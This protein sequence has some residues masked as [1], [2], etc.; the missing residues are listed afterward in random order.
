MGARAVVSGRERPV[1]YAT[2]AE[3]D[4]TSMTTVEKAAFLV[5]VDLFRDVPSDALAELASRVEEVAHV[6]GEVLVDG[7]ATEAR[8]LVVLDG[9]I[10]VLREGQT[11]RDLGRGDAVGLLAVLGVPQEET[12][13]AA[14]PCR[15]L[16]IPPEEYL[17]ALADHPAFALSNL[18]ALA[19]RLQ[20]AEAD[21]SAQRPPVPAAAADDTR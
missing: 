5:E 19:R 17:D 4:E 20:R 10:R 16:A 11:V 9:T 13:V 6:E 15:T 8:L 14:G 3:R 1:A 21:L 2:L 12:V 7:E 18:R